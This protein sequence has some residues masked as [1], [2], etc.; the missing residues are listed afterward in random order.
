[1]KYRCHL[2]PEIYPNC[3]VVD[4]LVHKWKGKTGDGHFEIVRHD[5]Y[6]QRIWL[7]FKEDLAGRKSVHL[8]WALD[9]SFFKDPSFRNALKDVAARFL[10]FAEQ[11]QTR[12]VVSNGK[13]HPILSWSKSP[14]ECRL[15]ENLGTG[16]P[17]FV[18]IS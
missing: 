5:F 6:P 16:T 8:S 18:R 2:A 10:Q 17:A 12:P 4:E 11:E 3:N 9:E 15:P 14:E 13:H 1:M 7:L